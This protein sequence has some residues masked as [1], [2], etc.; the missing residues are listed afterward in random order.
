MS[1]ITY[2]YFQSI[3]SMNASF[4]CEHGSLVKHSYFDGSIGVIIELHD[5]ECKVLWA[6]SPTE[7]MTKGSWK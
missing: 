7:A 3:S 5:R 4:G 1:E 6:V 2:E